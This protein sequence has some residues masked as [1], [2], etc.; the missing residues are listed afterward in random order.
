LK[1]ADKGPGLGELSFSVRTGSP[2]IP[3]CEA[4][5][6][7]EKQRIREGLKLMERGGPF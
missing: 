7:T 4:M 5:K 2:S 1:Q 3:W 6:F